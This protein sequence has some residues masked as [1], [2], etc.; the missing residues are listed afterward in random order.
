MLGAGELRVARGHGVVLAEVLHLLEGD[1]VAR[2]VQPRVNEHGAVPGRQDEAV[3]VD[4]LGVAGVVA[5]AALRAEEDG[6]HLGAAQREAQVARV[7]GGDGVHREAARLVGRLCFM[8]V[9]IA[10]GKVVLR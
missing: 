5:E 8:D 1:V 4:P 2:E 7:S 10:A 3:A 9:A 6:A